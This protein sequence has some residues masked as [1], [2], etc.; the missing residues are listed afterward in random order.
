MY[1]YYVLFFFCILFSFIFPFKKRKYFYIH[2]RSFIQFLFPPNR[3]SK[4]KIVAIKLKKR[5]NEQEKLISE[6]QAQSKVMQ[7]TLESDKLDISTNFFK[8]MCGFWILKKVCKKIAELSFWKK[9]MQFMEVA[10]FGLKD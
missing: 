4:L 2:M 9:I 8:L 1:C 6:L 10:L 7:S 3:Y 5:V